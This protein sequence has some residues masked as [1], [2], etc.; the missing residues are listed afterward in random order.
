M[1]L[2]SGLML[3]IWPL[4]DPDQ[5]AALVSALDGISRRHPDSSVM[6]MA[7]T[8]LVTTRK[9]LSSEAGRYAQRIVEYVRSN[10]GKADSGPLLRFGAGL[11][12]WSPDPEQVR[13]SKDIRALASSYFPDLV[14]ELDTLMPTT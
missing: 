7:E 6:V 12:G 13:I 2:S 5:W 4:L 1:S 3:K 10:S 8:T 14:A 11:V 9:A